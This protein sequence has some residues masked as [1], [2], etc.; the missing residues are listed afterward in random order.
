M[1]KLQ[2]FKNR[3]SLEKNVPNMISVARIVL[4]RNKHTG[5]GLTQLQLA[6]M[7]SVSDKTVSKWECGGGSPDL[8]MFEPLSEILEID[9]KSLV[10]GE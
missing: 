9:I 5:K 4:I 1:K 10:N 6:E 7:L 8:S 2:G 3:V